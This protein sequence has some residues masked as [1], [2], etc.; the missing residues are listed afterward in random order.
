MSRTPED[1]AYM[2]THDSKL[3]AILA[4]ENNSPG[5]L[6]ADEI[7]YN[8]KTMGFVNTMA[9]LSPSEKSMYDKMVAS[10]NTAAAAGMSVI[11][12]IRTMGHSAAGADG[13]T[14]DP[15]NT[16]ITASNVEKYFS[17]SINNTG[18]IKSQFQALIQYLQNNSA[19]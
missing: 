6:T 3:A 11:A 4:K 14:Y 15:I 8:Q 5:T 17:Q 13:T 18:Q 7:D 19:A 1:V 9:N 12:F 2:Q 10:G 16:E